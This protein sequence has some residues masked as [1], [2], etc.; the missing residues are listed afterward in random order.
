MRV[1][2]K[3]NPSVIDN[4][5]YVEGDSFDAKVVLEDCVTDARLFV[6][7]DDNVFEDRFQYYL[8]V[9]DP[10]SADS[11]LAVE[12]NTDSSGEEDK[13]ILEINL[14]TDSDGNLDNSVNNIMDIKNDIND[15]DEFNAWIYG[16]SGGYINSDLRT[17]K[18]CKIT[19]S[20]K[21]TTGW[22]DW[23]N[24]PEVW[25]NYQII[26]QEIETDEPGKLF[27]CV[28][29]P[30]DVDV[31]VGDKF[32][33]KNKNEITSDYDGGY[34][35]QWVYLSGRIDDFYPVGPEIGEDDINRNLL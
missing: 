21:N 24:I 1:L 28:K 31:E 16:N 9:V 6:S 14:A 35:V 27:E 10:D 26:F 34:Y 2:V 7:L 17:Q 22:N 8:E 4:H 18:F 33:W 12:L 15:L 5:G 29:A 3:R 23:N 20:L 13:Y 11:S 30:D 32:D 19:N 25:K